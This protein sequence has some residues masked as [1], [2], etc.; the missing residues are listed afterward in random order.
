MQAKDDLEKGLLESRR[1][2]LAEERRQRM[3]KERNQ[4]LND[5]FTDVKAAFAD[6][7]RRRDTLE[8]ELEQEEVVH[9]QHRKDEIAERR[10]T[11]NLWMPLR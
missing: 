5:Q 7:K 4:V 11:G 2:Q 6:T 9:K 3:L 8:K 10:A 1:A